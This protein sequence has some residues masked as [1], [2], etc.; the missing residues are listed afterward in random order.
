[1]GPVRLTLASLALT[2]AL[3]TGALAQV[4][5]PAQSR[6]SSLRTGAFGLGLFASPAGGI[7][8]SFRHHLPGRFSYQL[9]AGVLK[10][11]SH[12]SY[13]VGGE[14]QYTLV[15]EPGHR[16][17][18][19]AATGYYYS[20]PPDRNDI[21]APWRIGLGIGGELPIGGRFT[22]MGDLLFTYFSD[23]SLFPFPAGGVFYYFD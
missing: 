22:L 19:A 10:S 15:R 18:V 1:M 16:L 11:S 21:E 17:F 12:V 13:A 6:E 7:G 5:A 9:T 8:L 4:D 20:G 14:F 3:C 23:G 2:I